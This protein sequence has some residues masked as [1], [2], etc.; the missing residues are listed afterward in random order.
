MKYRHR[1]LL[2]LIVLTC[3]LLLINRAHAQ[4]D[5]LPVDSC[6][7][8]G[9]CGGGPILPPPPDPTPAPATT[10]KCYPDDQLAVRVIGALP[11]SPADGKIHI[12]YGFIDD[13]GNRVS[14]DDDNLGKAL[15][16]AMDDWNAKSDLT[17][18]VFDPVSAS[19]NPTLKFV[20][21]D[22][23]ER[24]GEEPGVPGCI[25]TQVKTGFVNFSSAF[26]TM[27]AANKGAAATAFKHEV[28]EYFGLQHI[29]DPTF[30]SI[31]TGN[32]GSCASP[33]FP[34]SAISDAD[35]RKSQE[36]IAKATE[37]HTNGGSGISDGPDYHYWASTP[38]YEYWSAYDIYFQYWTGD[39]YRTEY[40]F[41]VY[42]L[43]FSTC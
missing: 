40:L 30:A 13:V 3:G 6:P 25:A 35:A 33:V 23:S 32:S 2:S 36:C 1:I 42:V 28:S 15:K 38:C 21:T 18:V 41:T 26:A 5:L 43:E 39:G 9:T 29:A 12:K 20:L 24:L 17:K 7:D 27:A 22:D 31:A 11:H 8:P 4:S 16:L 14:H 19:E 37:L 34:T 10:L